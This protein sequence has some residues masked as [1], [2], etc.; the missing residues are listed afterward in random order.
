MSLE[1]RREIKEPNEKKKLEDSSF[2]QDDFTP[3]SAKIEP[4]EKEE[5]ERLLK[6]KNRLEAQVKEKKLSEV[7]KY[8]NG[9]ARIPQEYEEIPETEKDTHKPVEED[10]IDIE[11]T[12]ELTEVEMDVLEIAKE[13]LKLKR[14]DSEF[15]IESQSQIQKYP[16]I[17]KLYA[18]CIA[19]LSFNK[20]Y[21]KN[22]IF[23]AIRGLEEKNWIVTNERRTKLEIIN[24]DKLAGILKFIE[25][26]SIEKNW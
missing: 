20:G 22:E 4:I 6:E 21:S 11:A 15:E 10:Y 13:I 23:L 25:T 24:N 12:E 19:K 2:R 14:Y 8:E 18:K 1:K 16:I 9:I 26:N 3:L 17:E 5:L 7:Q